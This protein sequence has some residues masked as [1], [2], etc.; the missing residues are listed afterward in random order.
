MTLPL[1]KLLNEEHLHELASNNITVDPPKLIKVMSIGG[2]D[3]SLILTYTKPKNSISS[4]NKFINK[5]INKFNS[6]EQTLIELHEY[7]T[8]TYP[9]VTSAQIGKLISDVVST[10][11][12][13]IKVITRLI[14]AQVQNVAIQKEFELLDNI[15]DYPDVF[16]MARNKTRKI[17]AFLGDTNSG[18]TW[19]AMAKIA[20]TTSSAYMAPLRLLAHETYEYLN[21]QGIPCSLV[22][23]EERIDIPNAMCVSSTVECFDP[24]RE[25]DLVVIDEIQMIDDVDRGAF[26][27]QA[28]V[29]ANAKEIIVTG[30]P[31]YAKRITEIAE[32]LGDDIEIE[33]FQRK[34]ELKPLKKPVSLQNIK[35]NTA[36]VAFSKKEVYNI[37]RQLPKHISSTVLY[38]A[39]G[40]EVRKHQAERF[41]NGEVDVIV[42]TDCIGMGLNLPIETVLF[43]AIEKYDGHSVKPLSVMLT[44]QI[45]G[46]AGRYGKFD[47]GYYGGI[48]NHKHGFIKEQINRK[49]KPNKGK[50]SVLP[51]KR[52]MSSLLDKYDLADI[53]I[54]WSDDITF[55]KEDTLFEPAA[56]DRQIRVA[57]TLQKRYED[58]KKYWG[59]IY[60]PVDMDKQYHEF[61]NI[62]DQLYNNDHIKLPDPNIQMMGQNGLE[63][64]L[65]ELNIFMWF[66][67]KY[68]TKFIEDSERFL[69]DMVD[70]CN[71]HLNI[72]LKK[73]N[74]K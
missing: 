5:F 19:N 24:L 25:F 49:V 30:P 36:I 6:S 27:V 38:G 61:I 39:L 48:D 73:L 10:N 8:T 46:R 31:E 69:L 54:S 2:H 11:A 52:Y 3:I 1:H 60:C 13:D 63:M 59:L 40:Y 43:S 51:P 23:G 12:F 55:N 74:R 37:Q 65:K 17:T 66:N 34:S 7:L 21:E 68:P 67:N 18:K 4:K 22:T 56:L 71:Y 33:I 41:R 47:T 14:T 64:F 50:L 44:K 72:Y 16:P 32:Y 15:D 35:P 28:L 20:D 70:E 45:A 42:T 57:E 62:A 26:F 58:Y 53:L 29:G 9:L